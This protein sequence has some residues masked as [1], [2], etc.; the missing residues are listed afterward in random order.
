MT[1]STQAMNNVNKVQTP[2]AGN[3]P[4]QGKQESELN[5]NDL[6]SSAMG[7]SAPNA[8][9]NSIENQL[10]ES[11]YKQDKPKKSSDSTANA[12]AAQA[13]QTA[14]WAQRNWMQTTP[15]QQAAPPAAVM[16]TEPVK[17]AAAPESAPRATEKTADKITEK[18]TENKTESKAS[19]SDTT[20]TADAPTTAQNSAAPETANEAANEAANKAASGSKQDTQISL[21]SNTIPSAAQEKP[22]DGKT[23]LAA[24]LPLS[25]ST[26]SKPADLPATTPGTEQ[27]T[28]TEQAGAD[29]TRPDI[30][31]TAQL[32]AEA[33]LSNSTVQVRNDS[34][35]TANVAAATGNSNAVAAQLAPQIA[36]QIAQQAQAMGEG[37]GDEGLKVGQKILAAGSLQSSNT[38]T[39]IAAGTN[40][41]TSATG[42]AQQ[43]LIK[44]PVNQPGF[45]KELGQ[46]VQ[47]AIG[48]N[49]STVDIRVN[50]ESFGPM[51]M[52]L[53][54]KGQQVQLVIRTQDEASANLLTQALGGLKEVLAQNGLQLNQVQIQHGNTPTPQGQGNQGQA[55]FEQNR[56]QGQ[57]NGQRS[58]SGDNE[59]QDSGTPAAA[60]RKPEGKLDLFA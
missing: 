36:P 49:L 27:N 14:V 43:T 52:R 24:E 37:F 51:N 22:L 10:R 53:V 50:P 57:N 28:L 12:E 55:Q 41:L 46:T 60:S 30:K 39:G 47:W 17:Q 40:G 25:T 16:N 1:T 26:G 4:K 35:A 18:V 11:L 23:G 6:F 9:L 59:Q 31:T 15:V 3:K 29:K 48:K 2:T 8:Q 7:Q 19:T 56:Q 38:G 5:F 32:K 20:K 54:Q 44:T 45:A 33:A 34:A 21:V 58:G 13:A 42:I